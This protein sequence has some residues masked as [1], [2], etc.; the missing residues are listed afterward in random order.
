[1][2]VADPLGQRAQGGQA[3]P[4]GGRGGTDPFERRDSLWVSRVP[5]LSEDLVD[6]HQNRATTHLS[7]RQ[8]ADELQIRGGW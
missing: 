3:D 5:Q 8:T 6:G 7:A 2:V 1:M 4:E